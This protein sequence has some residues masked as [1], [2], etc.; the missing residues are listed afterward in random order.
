VANQS[1]S[2]PEKSVAFGV[3]KHLPTRIY[4]TIEAWRKQFEKEYCDM[5][6]VPLNV[7]YS[8]EQWRDG[9]YVNADLQALWE[10]FCD[11]Q[12]PK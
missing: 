6:G 12:E 2:Q 5:A 8:H 10:R 11:P 4:M 1:E 3:A 7:F 9:R